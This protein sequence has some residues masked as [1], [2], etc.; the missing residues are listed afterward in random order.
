MELRR[1]PL[2]DDSF[3][4][5]PVRDPIAE[6]VG[7]AVAS[8]GR[9]RDVDVLDALRAK[10]RDEVRPQLLGLGPDAV[11][12]VQHDELPRKSGRPTA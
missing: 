7:V 5:D 1:D 4:L 8:R 2:A 10:A 11:G 3:R 6:L 9:D 12:L